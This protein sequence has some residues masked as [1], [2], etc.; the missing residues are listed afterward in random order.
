MLSLKNKIHNCSAPFCNSD[1][2]ILT[3]GRFV[4]C[5]MTDRGV[6]MYETESMIKV[7]S[8]SPWC[9]A[10]HSGSRLP[11]AAST[12]TLPE[13]EKVKAN[14]FMVVLVKKCVR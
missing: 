5:I 14:I 9:S 7:S 8:F 12:S 4:L 13:Y 2:S 3:S 1:V 10:V 6:I 11:A